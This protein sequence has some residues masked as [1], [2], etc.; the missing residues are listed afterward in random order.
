MSED[1][2]QRAGLTAEAVQASVSETQE[3]LDELKTQLKA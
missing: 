3:A 2:L 1:V